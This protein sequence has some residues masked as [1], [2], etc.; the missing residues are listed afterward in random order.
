M[1]RKNRRNL[2]FASFNLLNRLGPMQLSY[3]PDP[4]LRTDW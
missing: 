4:P 1:A 3:A 2:S